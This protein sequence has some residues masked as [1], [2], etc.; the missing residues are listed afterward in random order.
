VTGVQTCALPIS[1]LREIV[2][3]LLVSIHPETA[4]RLHINDGDQVLIESPRGS[5]EAR[6]Y[7]TEG[8]ARGV[9]KVPSH[10][11]GRNNVNLLMD[12]ENCAPM[13]GST[14]LR[15]QLCRVQEKG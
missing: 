15:C 1:I 3:D 6:A 8:I 4:K 2:P 9:V 13:I 14:Q 5:M 10:W 7:L 12:N 11:S